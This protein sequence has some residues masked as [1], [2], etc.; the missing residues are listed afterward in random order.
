MAIAAE[1]RNA[2]W[3]GLFVVSCP[4]RA[5]KGT[6]CPANCDWTDCCSDCH[7]A[8]CPF[9]KISALKQRVPQISAGLGGVLGR[10]RGRGK[11][12]WRTRK[13]LGHMVNSVFCIFGVVLATVH[14]QPT[15]AQTSH[16]PT[17]VSADYWRQDK[18]DSVQLYPGVFDCNL[19]HC[20]E[21][22]CGCSARI[23]S[24]HHSGG[25]SCSFLVTHELV[26]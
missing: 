5:P 21:R 24:S 10:R 2:V 9:K 15:E 1:A 25:D 26:T 23:D 8:C 7:N 4:H 12:G 16:P 6:F 19:R 20:R 3:Q 13:M 11:R 18:Q 17:T 14:F 22:T